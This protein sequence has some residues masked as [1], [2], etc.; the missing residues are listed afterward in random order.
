M[1]GE[2][3]R[4][5]VLKALKCCAGTDNGKTCLYIAT[6]NDCPYEDL[7]GEYED[8][9][10]EC[11]KAL[12]ADALKLLKE[13]EP[14]VM[15]LEEVIDHY[16]LPPV[17]VDDFGAQEDYMQDIV[18]LYFDF[19]SDDSWSVHWRGYQSVRKYLDDWKASYGKK[20]ICWTGKPTD[21]QRKA[22]QWG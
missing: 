8:A 19:P 13:Q 2:G 10:Y 17:F 5:K 12:A 22:V 18:P 6:A 9:Y 11:T 21:E 1:N 7:C 3:L 16:S 4:E 20:W 15:T 14:R